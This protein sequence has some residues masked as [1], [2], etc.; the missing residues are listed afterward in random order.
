MMLPSARKISLLPIAL[1]ACVAF[2]QPL[3]ALTNET[4]STSGP[5][6]V[7]S[8][9]P[10]ATPKPAIAPA[11]IAAPQIAS[12]PVTA[13]S[14]AQVPPAQGTD[15]WGKVGEKCTLV[16]P[17]IG[18]HISVGS[19]KEVLADLAGN[20]DPNSQEASL[21]LSEDLRIRVNHGEMTEEEAGLILDELARFDG[22]AYSI[23]TEDQLKTALSL[24]KDASL[25]SEE[26]RELVR[27]HMQVTLGIGAV[28]ASYL[29]DRMGVEV[30]DESDSA[31]TG[32][33]DDA[34]EPPD[35]PELQH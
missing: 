31:L 34:A 2:G 27:V 16:T 30:G 20:S 12:N 6:P 32:S 26:Y 29:S 24:P 33:D 23:P 19:K 17:Y 10:D 1:L 11:P 3:W 7:M 22:A 8:S 28:T 13:S 15:C 18:M 5:L 35:S 14:P 25:S 21:H 9:V 4:Y